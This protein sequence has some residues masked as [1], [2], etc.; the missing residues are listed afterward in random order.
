MKRE[1]IYCLITAALL[2]VLVLIVVLPNRPSDA[3]PPP[4][5]TPPTTIEVDREGS[6]IGI[7]LPVQTE[8][9]ADAAYLLKQQLAAKGYGVELSYGDGTVPGQLEAMNA[10]F[11]KNTDCVIV[12]PADSATL[13]NTQ[14]LPGEDPVPL[15]SY[16]SLL[17]DTD[18]VEGY[19][20]YD[21]Y[22]MGQEIA[23]QV[24]RTMAL[25][26][27]ADQNR[28]HT[29]ELFMGAPRDYNAVLLHQG[30]R[31]ILDPYFA[32]GVLTCASGRLAFEDNCISG[33]SAEAAAAAC[34]TRLEKYYP[35]NA[36]D[37]CITGSDN[38]AA[39][40]I[41]AL[42]STGIVSG[43]WPLITGNGATEA[44]LAYLSAGKLHLT[45]STDAAD[46]A[47]ACVAMVDM[48]L[49]GLQPDF[50]LAELSN[51]LRSVPTALCDFELVYG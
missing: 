1:H 8:E 6:V 31:S 24:A 9:W 48:V 32:S 36:P 44:G 30:L 27:A 12:A 35:G 17:M 41:N 23:R 45:V 10:L 43:N 28:S 39:G 46:P 47:K 29:I 15:I 18:T 11:R 22:A 7:C 49:F 13:P 21:Y 50:T 2:A 19:V 38:I 40:V 26:T 20:C 3:T 16:G 51:H 25:D 5:T 14:L 33:W 42:E 37:I 4:E 34:A